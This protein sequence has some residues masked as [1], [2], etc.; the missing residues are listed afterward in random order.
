MK[1][2]IFTCYCGCEGI[3]ISELDEHY[4]GSPLINF[5][6]WQYGTP[7]YSVKEKLRAIRYILKHGHPYKDEITLDRETAEGLAQFLLGLLEKKGNQ[8]AIT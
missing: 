8:N 2:Q 4:D 7:H 5:S 3:I 1:E 6:T